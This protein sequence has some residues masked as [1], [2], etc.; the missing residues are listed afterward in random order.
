MRANVNLFWL[1]AGFF[2]LADIT[3]IVW[4][5][6][7]TGQVEWVGTV[8][9]GLSAVLGAFIAFYVGRVHKA[10]GAELPED[11]LDADIDDGDPELGF[12]SPWSW[13]PLILGGSAALGFLGLAVGFWITYIAVGLFLVA[14]AGWVYEYYRGYF[15]R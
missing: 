4:S 2:L 14:I 1:L 8:G 6:L 3:Y 9:I 5:L 11:R 15:A 7:D 13:W 12:F 10:Q